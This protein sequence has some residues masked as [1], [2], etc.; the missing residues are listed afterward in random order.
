MILP[1]VGSATATRGDLVN[2]NSG[3]AMAR[4]E[5]DI[6][7]DRVSAISVKRVKLGP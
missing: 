5:E 2:T 7:S 6:A 1:E 3:S 4:V